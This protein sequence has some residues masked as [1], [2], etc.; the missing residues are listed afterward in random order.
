MNIL[1]SDRASFRSEGQTP[2][3]TDLF[4]FSAALWA[5]HRIHYDRPYTTEQE[6][7]PALL[8]HGPLQTSFIVQALEN[9]LGDD[10]VL[11]GISYRHTQPFYLGGSVH[12]EGVLAPEAD[13]DGNRVIDV[14][15]VAEDGAVTTAATCM[16]KPRPGGSLALP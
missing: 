15:C 3:S 14:R 16:V 12:V 2:T 9:W 6:G 1:Q 10:G 11:A 5:G 13:A 4:F 7:Y 8:V